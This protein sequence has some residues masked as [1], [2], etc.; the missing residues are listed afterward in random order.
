MSSNLSQF[1]FAVAGTAA[2]IEF[3][4]GYPLDGP[5]EP[6]VIVQVAFD[7]ASG[8]L[9]DAVSSAV[10]TSN[11]TP[12]YSVDAASPWADVSPGISYIQANNARHENTAAGIP[13]IGTNDATIEIIFATVAGFGSAADNVLWYV[14]DTGGGTLRTQ[15]NLRPTGNQIRLTIDYFGVSQN[16]DYPMSTVLYND[17]LP[18]K[19]RLT[20]DRNGNA[21]FYLD[22]TSLG[23]GGIGGYDGANITSNRFSVGNLESS[24]ANVA[25]N[26]TI[27]SLRISTNLTNNS[28]GPN[29][30]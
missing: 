4:Y 22:G 6:D 17:N 20:M 11:G 10:L 25:A 24:F 2:D 30:G 3:S 23:I 14:S 29:G 21:T 18:H 8:N 5:F 12:I 28:G 16:F 27:Y 9:V 1:F 19:L 26:C 13:A 7:V 15:I